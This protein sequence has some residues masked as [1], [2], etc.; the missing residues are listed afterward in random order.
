MKKLNIIFM[1][2]PDFA[3]VALKALYEQGHNILAVYCQPPREKGRGKKIQKNPTHIW[4][5]DHNISVLTPLNF[6]NADDI[7][8]FKAFNADVSIVAAYGLILP[9][10]ILSA[11]RLG[12]VNIHGSILPR[13]RGAAPIQRAIM[14]GDKET[15]ITTM[16]MDEGLDTGGILEYKTLPIQNETTTT[17]LYQSMSDLG[18]ELI[19]STIDK[20][21]RNQIQ[22]QK[23]SEVGVTYAHKLLKEEG[24]LNFDQD[25]SLLFNIIKGLT[26]QISIW[27]EENTIKFRILK[28]KVHAENFQ[29]DIGKLIQKQN[30]LYIQC[31]D[32]S[33]EILS[34]QP[35]GGV[36]M[37]TEA[38]LRGYPHIGC[39]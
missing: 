24:R 3:L 13:W 36:I 21:A 14:A 34:L 29:I 37:N 32:C 28:V 27:Y 26:P 12:C 18:A 11:P 5:E 7:N 2:T 15:G 31:R 19:L 10:S 17:D 33:L 1:G 35:D 38:F 6:K 4:A 23:Q 9:L 25:A 20:L 16:L 22:P 8:I 30:S 39:T